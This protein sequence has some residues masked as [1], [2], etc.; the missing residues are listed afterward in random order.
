MKRREFLAALAASSAP[1]AAGA[2]TSPTGTPPQSASRQLRVTLLG[3]GTPAP[4]LVRQGSGYLIELWGQD[5]M[6]LT[7]SGGG[8]SGIEVKGA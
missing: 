8:V 5:L 2:Q 7:V 1:V 3:T 4:S 6:Q